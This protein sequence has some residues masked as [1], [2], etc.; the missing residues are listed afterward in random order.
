MGWGDKFTAMNYKTLATLSK[1]TQSVFLIGLGYISFDVRGD[2]FCQ[3]TC[4]SFHF[5]VS[6]LGIGRSIFLPLLFVLIWWRQVLSLE[7]CLGWNVTV[8]DLW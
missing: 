4:L 7:Q 8:A 1:I 2:I 6:R 3:C 5:L